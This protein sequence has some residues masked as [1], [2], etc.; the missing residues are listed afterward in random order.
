M[1]FIGNAKEGRRGVKFYAGG[2][3]LLLLLYILGS[4]PL[5][6]LWERQFPSHEFELTNAQQIAQF[7]SLRLYFWMLFPFV[8]IFIG[9]LF[10]LVK[11]HRRNLLSL[12]T[13]AASFRWA[14][15]M[16]FAFF[17]L[18]FQGLFTGL[19]WW[20][21]SDAQHAAFQWNFD[22]GKFFPLLLLSLVLIPIQATAEELIFRVYALQG[23]YA[24]T[25]KVWLSMMLSA[26]FFAT[27][28]GS[29]PEVQA[30]G[31]AIIAYY[32]LAGLFLALITV[33]DNGI[34][35]SMAYHTLNN[36]FSAVVVS[37]TWQVFHTDAL[38]LDS[39]APGSAWTYLISGGF[40][41]TFL[42]WIL[43]KKFNWKPLGALR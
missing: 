17:V 21:L 29:N 3:L 15:F 14:R 8:L 34:E 5:L 11:V 7:G 2:I 27:V 22:A 24:R 35:L 18:L 1:Q 40:T 28:H 42:Y 19:Q 12:F 30:L 39:S 41:F 43:A 26:I 31:P 4:L 37:S 20:F 33:Q 16:W 6:M 13:S 36:L 25:G 9:L 23:L 32:F 38:W 10:Y